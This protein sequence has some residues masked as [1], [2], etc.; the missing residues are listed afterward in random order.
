MVSFRMNLK[1][2]YQK[3]NYLL[4]KRHYY[5]VTA[6]SRVLPDFLIIGG[7]RCGTTSLYYN[8]CQHP[9][10]LPAAYDEIG[11]FDDNFHL[12]LNWYRSMFPTKN[13]MN[14]VRRQTGKAVT[15]EDTPFYIW[16]RDAMKRI[17]ELLPEIKLIV[18][19]RNPVN[20]TYSNYHLGCRD[21]IENRSFSQAVEDDI[22]LINKKKEK[23]E[24]LSNL[25]FK[26][27]YIGKSLY[28]EQLEQ[29]FKIFDAKQIHVI[30]T[31]DLRDN[32][33]NTMKSVYDFLGL[34]DFSLETYE[35]QKMF[36][37]DNMDEE[38]RERL[39]TYF[40]SHNEQLSKLIK[41]RCW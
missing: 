5:G 16:N 2:I 23:G 1:K 24:T 33:E 20:R 12:G 30:F 25:D 28:F 41:S 34:D 10:V 31:E 38:I 22:E 21:N 3:I 8:I 36:E 39:T 4:I 17:K 37:Y 11:F 9:S 19:L 14:K 15:G 32:P 40:K 7:V 29:W 13:T 35:K 26:K 6:S 18:I 27:T